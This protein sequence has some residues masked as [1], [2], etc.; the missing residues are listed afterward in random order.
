MKRT[1]FLIIVSFIIALLIVQPKI[2]YGRINNYSETEIQDSSLV[3]FSKQSHIFLYPNGTKNYSKVFLNTINANSY[4]PF[5]AV[6]SKLSGFSNYS[7][8]GYEAHDYEVTY[9]GIILN[10]YDNATYNFPNWIALLGLNNTTGEGFN[11]NI[12][13]SFYGGIF[14]AYELT[15][16][17]I[18][19]KKTSFSWISAN[20]LYRNSFNA[21]HST[22]EMHNGWSITLS[23]SGSWAN[24]G[25]LEST[26]HSEWS[27][28]FA[29]KKTINQYH[30]LSFTV[31]GAP[32]TNKQTDYAPMDAFNLRKNNYYSPNFGYQEGKLRNANLFTSHIPIGIMNHRWEVS[33]RLELNS[34]FAYSKGSSSFSEL[35]WNNAY[36]PNPTYYLNMPYYWEYIRHETAVDYFTNEWLNNPDFYQ[37]NWYQLYFLN[38]NNQYQIEN[39]NGIMGNSITGNKAKYYL[40]LNNR[41]ITDLHLAST[42]PYQINNRLKLTTGVYYQNSQQ[43]YYK[44]MDDLL[45]AD[46]H[47]DILNAIYYL[48]EFNS[49]QSDLNQP[50]RV[51]YE[52]ESFAYD[53]IANINSYN[54]HVLIEYKLPRIEFIAFGSVGARSIKREGQMEHEAFK[55]NSQ[56]PSETFLFGNYNFRGE[57]KLWILKNHSIQ[58]NSFILSSPPDFYDLFVLPQASN[59]IANYNNKTANGV[60]IGYKAN[61]QYIS[62]TI[63][64]Y[65]TN[66]NNQSKNIPY[67]DEVVNLRGIVSIEGL[68]QVHEGVELGVDFKLSRYIVINLAAAHG[69]YYYSS[70]PKT[71]IFLNYLEE[72]FINNEISYVKGFRVPNI[73]QTLLGLGIAFQS[74]NNWFFEVRGNYYEN[75]YSAFSYES[76]TDL[77]LSNLSLPESELNELWQQSKLPGGGTI[78]FSFGKAWGIFN[79]QHN[80]ILNVL[81]ANALDNQNI[82]IGGFESNGYLAKNRLMSQNKY[83]YMY[84]RNIFVNLSYRF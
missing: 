62:A 51:V 74:S 19:S 18:S 43:H 32:I 48:P 36:N 15:S 65:K 17:Q 47:L 20:H 13:K 26:A 31:M 54:G 25:Y 80:I 58:I 29:A 81:V 77:S 35:E 83:M 3:D 82:V 61:T 37:I 28:L 52:G 10:S 44:T 24:E 22:G 67:F 45:G 53:Y 12:N 46:F 5:I 27:Y 4:D 56:G 6:I 8:R 33:N 40:A 69:N 34:S 76:R 79:K 42:L 72:P 70:R 59:L 71:S 49:F 14:G 73:P 2:I 50:N 57:T 21:V 11:H 68:N 23:G 41:D 84:G 16:S 7:I 63:N 55:G 60:S 9:D 39:A 1:P 78:D 64:A 66:I 30:A 75:I 38:S